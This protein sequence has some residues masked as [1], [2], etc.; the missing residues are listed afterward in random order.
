MENYPVKL[1]VLYEVDKDL[2]T[3]SKL[4]EKYYLDRY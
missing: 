3:P 4:F 2:F 1:A